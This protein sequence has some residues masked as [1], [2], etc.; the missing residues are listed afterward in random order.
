MSLSTDYT[1]MPTD[2]DQTNIIVPSKMGKVKQE[3]LSQIWL[4]WSRMKVQV[5][6]ENSEE[7]LTSSTCCAAL[8]PGTIN[9]LEIR[10][11]PIV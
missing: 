9:P 11:S 8:G 7:G 6:T 10:R 1:V 5:R 2:F 4:V 3:Q